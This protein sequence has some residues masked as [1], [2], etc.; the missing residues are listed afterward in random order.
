MMSLAK[1]QHWSRK[2]LVGIQELS[3]AEIGQVLDTAAAFKEVGQR[4]VK[5]VPSLRGKTMVNLFIEPSTR[6]R[7]SFELA[8]K[9]LSAL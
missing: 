2:D 1:P 5:K 9:R 3:T 6:T 4:T 7:N 8:A